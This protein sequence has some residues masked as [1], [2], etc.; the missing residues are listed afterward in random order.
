MSQDSNVDLK[1]KKKGG[2]SKIQVTTL[3]RLIIFFPLLHLFIIICSIY[4]AYLYVHW[5]MPLIVLSAI[6]LFPLLSHRLHD[7]FFPLTDEKVIIPNGQYPAWWGS[8][9]IQYIF[10]AMPVLETP[11]R[12]V[13]GLYSAW[14][15]GWGSQIGRKVVWPPSLEITDRSLMVIGDGTVIGHHTG[16]YCH[17][18]NPTKDGRLLLFVKK[19]VIGSYCF[20][21]SG[22]RIGPGN[23]IPDRSKLDVLT[24]LRISPG[25]GANQL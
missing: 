24:D 16:Y 11:L 18:L 10:I 23:I 3:G 14:L 2:P 1:F 21:G 8:Y 15:R 19:I 5:A 13:P 7:Y 6:Y 20:I 17:V 4:F 9:Q 12:L 25:S 22:S